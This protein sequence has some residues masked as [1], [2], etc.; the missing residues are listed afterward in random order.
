MFQSA[1][2]VARDLGLRT[3]QLQ[4]AT[5]LTRLRRAAGK[6]TETDDLRA[7]YG[8]F[9]DGLDTRDLAEARAALDEADARVG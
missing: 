2:E 5:R 4:A 7:V 6:P 3:P 1:L 9:A 8:T